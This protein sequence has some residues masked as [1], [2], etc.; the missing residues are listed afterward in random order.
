VGFTLSA[1]LGLRKVSV[2][3]YRGWTLEA[4]EIIEVNVR[5]QDIAVCILLEFRAYIANSYPGRQPQ[6]S[7]APPNNT[8]TK[9]ITLDLAV[10]C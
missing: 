7:P 4:E 8:R 6:P 1:N 10:R 3:V 9:L 2:S 5:E